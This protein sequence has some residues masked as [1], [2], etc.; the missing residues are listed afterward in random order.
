MSLL[1]NKKCCCTQSYVCSCHECG[2]SFN[3]SIPGSGLLIDG[4]SDYVEDYYPDIAWNQSGTVYNYIAASHWSNMLEL[5]LQ[6]ACASANYWIGRADSIGYEAAF[7]ELLASNLFYCPDDL[8]PSGCL[9]ETWCCNDKSGCK[10]QSFGDQGWGVC[11][12]TPDVL[13]APY[14]GNVAFSYNGPT[15]DLCDDFVADYNV[16]AYNIGTEPCPEPGTYNATFDIS[17]GTYPIDTYQGTC[18]VII[19]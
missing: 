5:M 17:V 3:W 6:L 4:T 8:N 7:D 10:W 13:L 2:S 15:Q 16:F 1:L 9:Q 18:Q 12:E 19:S 11:S 14:G